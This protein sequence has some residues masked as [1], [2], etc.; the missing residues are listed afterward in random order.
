MF[1]M[2]KNELVRTRAT[3]YIASTSPKSFYKTSKGQTM[4][5]QEHSRTKTSHLRLGLNRI[6]NAENIEIAFNWPFVIMKYRFIDINKVPFLDVQKVDNEF[7]GPFAY[8]K[9]P[10]KK[11]HPIR[12]FRCRKLVRMAFWHLET[13]SSTSPKSFLKRPEG[14]L[15]VTMPI[16]LLK[17]SLKQHRPSSFFW[18]P[19]CRKW[20]RVAFRHLETSPHRLQLSYVVLSDRVDCHQTLSR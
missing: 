11:L 5:S 2:K 18:C 15:W 19:V 8:W 16:R 9:H 3:S 20:V 6:F 7:S 1:R 13:T 17:T 12:F 14:R 4:S 10:L